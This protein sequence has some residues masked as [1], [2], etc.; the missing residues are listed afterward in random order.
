MQSRV[1][2]SIEKVTKRT[3]KLGLKYLWTMPWEIES[4]QSDMSLGMPNEIE[5]RKK[6]TFIG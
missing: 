1:G 5:K 3:D 6:R 2:I 4:K